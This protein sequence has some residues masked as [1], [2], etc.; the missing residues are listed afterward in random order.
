MIYVFDSSA[1]ISLFNNFYPSRFPSLWEKFD[2][3]VNERSIISVREVYNEIKERGDRLSEWAKGEKNFFQ[4]PSPEELAFVTE[5]FNIPHFQSLIRQKER[6]QGK[7]VADPLVIAKA[8]T[9]NG[10]VITQEVNRPNA[11]RIP[12]VCNHFSL[13]CLNLEGFM[14]RENW[15]F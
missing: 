5:I 14:E 2:L 8:K 13:D 15:T 7:P 12:N 10:S 11:A 9:L 6:L 3:L 4:Q 1:L